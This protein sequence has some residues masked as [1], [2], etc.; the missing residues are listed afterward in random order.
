MIL[1]ELMKS[2]EVR[3]NKVWKSLSPSMKHYALMYV[4][5]LKTDSNNIKDYIET[6][7]FI[8][9]GLSVDDLPNYIPLLSPEELRQEAYEV[10]GQLKRLREGA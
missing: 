8:K 3:R 1:D 7:R 4:L 2:E 5:R 6:H 10:I 9:S